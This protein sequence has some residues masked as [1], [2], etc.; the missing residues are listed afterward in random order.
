M[1][2]TKPCKDMLNMNAGEA[3]D[4]PSKTIQERVEY[5]T[6]VRELRERNSTHPWFT[7]ETE[8]LVKEQK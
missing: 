3:A 2:S 5:C 6:H 8:I 4:L 1:S 7:V